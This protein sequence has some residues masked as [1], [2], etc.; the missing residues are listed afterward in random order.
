MAFIVE[1]GS[2][3]PDATSLCSVEFADEYFS[4]RNKEEWVVDLTVQEKQGYLI[5]ASDWVEHTYR[6]RGNRAFCDQAFS[7][8][9]ECRLCCKCCPTNSDTEVPVNICKAVSEIAYSLMEGHLLGCLPSSFTPLPSDVP[10]CLIEKRICN[11][12]LRYQ[13]PQ[14]LAEKYAS[15][16]PADYASKLL[17][18]YTKAGVEMYSG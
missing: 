14:F 4:D 2:G 18:C 7:I 6:W 17:R 15:M 9:T 10:K 12:V 16:N 1:D 5:A 3:L 13:L 8:P 11:M